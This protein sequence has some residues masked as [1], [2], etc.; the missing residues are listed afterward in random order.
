MKYNPKRHERLSSLS[1]S[2]LRQLQDDDST[3]GML[4]IL[5]EMQNFLMEISGLPAI[6]LQPAAGAQGELTALFVAAAYFRD[7][8]E[9][10][11]RKVLVPDSAHGTNPASAALAGFE[12]VTVKSNAQGLV[13]LE[14]L[15][16]KL[17]DN[18]AVFMIT[19]PNTLGLFEK[20]IKTITATIPPRALT[21]GASTAPN[22]EQQYLGSPAPVISGWTG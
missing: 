15:K 2:R 21:L 3:Q 7:K 20:Q 19:N 22:A 5:W 13:D 10:H 17:D 18:T 1:G 16:A 6:S 12:A 4:K 14:D 9:S 8:K 11:R